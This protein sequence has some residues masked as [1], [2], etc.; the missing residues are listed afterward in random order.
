M[1]LELR[2]C[3]LCKT[4]YLYF[5][6]IALLPY[7]RHRTYLFSIGTVVIV[8][9]EPF[10]SLQGTLFEA[11]YLFWSFLF[12][13]YVLQENSSFKSIFILKK[14]LFLMFHKENPK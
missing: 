14:E 5:L 11:Y 1:I 9:F 7:L 3:D 4:R 12:C 13:Y 10:I 6:L 2:V 8:Q